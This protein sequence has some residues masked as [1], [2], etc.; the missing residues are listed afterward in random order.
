MEVRYFEYFAQALGAL[1]AV[2]PSLGLAIILLTVVVRLLILPLSIKQTR[3]MREMQRLQPEVKRIQAK[4][5]GDRQKLNEEMMA[6]YREH[7]V[8][9]FG[10]CLPLLL[11][12]PVFIG[13]FYV[14]QSPLKYLEGTSQLARDL[15]D[16]AL[17]VH[18]FFGLRLDCSPTWVYSGQESA[19]ASC[20][21]GFVALLPYLLLIVLLG[22][23]TFY[24]QRQ[25][26]VQ[27]GPGADAQTQQMQMV[28]R[29]MPALLMF[30][31]WGF[32]TGVI[33]YWLTTNVW[34]IGQQRIMF[35]VAPPL[36]T[37]GETKSADAPAKDKG[38][39]D[40]KPAKAAGKGSGKDAPRAGK[41]AAGNGRPSGAKPAP[42][43]KKKK[44][45]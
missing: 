43:T 7:N 16:H 36:P 45:R 3:S 1:Y 9:P 26:Q 41:P 35:R 18:R 31:S 24:Q 2:V 30:F 8:S 20:G 28:G 14:I 12:M 15:Q 40:G 39:G 17:A 10:G 11:Q 19:G 5:K 42:A 33:L 37:A 21:G 25:M 38:R 4:Y 13:L 22:L 34:T 27:R 44:K 32:P 23:T 29:I 6:L